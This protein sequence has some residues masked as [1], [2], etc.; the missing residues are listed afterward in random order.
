MKRPH[1]AAEDT[2]PCLTQTLP[3]AHCRTKPSDRLH[4]LPLNS[5][6]SISPQTHTFIHFISLAFSFSY[7]R[8]WLLSPL[9]LF[10]FHLALQAWQVKCVCATKAY[11]KG[12]IPDRGR[13]NSK[14]ELSERRTSYLFRSYF[15]RLSL[16]EL[17]LSLLCCQLLQEGE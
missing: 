10:K 16:K 9:S 1:D 2:L 12:K 3:A 15:A 6:P 7:P 14:E 8:G 13:M 11:E 17:K 4:F 5:I